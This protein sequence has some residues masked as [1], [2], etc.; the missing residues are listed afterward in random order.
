MNAW[1]EMSAL[2]ALQRRAAPVLAGAV[3]FGLGYV[4]SKPSPP[5]PSPAPAPEPELPEPTAAEMALKSFCKYGLP[6]DEHVVCKQGFAS[7]I[8]Y[9]LRIPN[10]VAEHYSADAAGDAPNVDRKHSKFI[11]DPSVPQEFRA[12]NEDY[13]G[14]KLSRGHL[15]PAGSHKNSQRCL[16]ET[17]LLSANILPQELSNNGSDW[18]RLE[19][20]ARKLTKTYKDVFV[21][22]GPLFL[23]EARLARGKGD[24]ETGAS[25]SGSAGIQDVAGSSPQQLGPLRKRIAY[26]VIGPHEV[27]VPTHLF[28]VV[29]A[30]DG[31]AP[32][33]VR[34]LGAFILPNGPVK[35][36]PDLDDFAVPLQTVEA[37]SGLTFFSSL[38]EARYSLPRLCGGDQRCGIGAMDGRIQGWKLFGHL[39]LARDC[40]ELTAAWQDVT[41]EGKKLDNMSL[42]RSA[43]EDKLKG[44]ACPLEGGRESEGSVSQPKH[45]TVRV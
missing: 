30:E 18:L 19:R 3:G 22:S 33:G 10:W 20:Y 28:K 44:L 24:S 37:A 27:A 5:S 43:H 26:D 29:M 41:S 38:G 32:S 23:P 25:P 42:M 9:R 21:V 15:A 34:R 8:N 1:L 16:D 4:A 11:A 7:S 35:G 13:R 12:G 17:F 2:L 39:K 40:E 14:S 31:E 45:A 6:S 36:H